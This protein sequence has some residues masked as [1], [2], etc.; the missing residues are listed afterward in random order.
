MK[1]ATTTAELNG[2]TSTPAEAVRAYEGTGFRYL[3]FSFYNAVSENGNYLMRDNWREYVLEALDVADKMGIKFVQAHAPSGAIRGEGSDTC[4]L[5]TERS[6]EACSMLGI[7]N[8]VIHSGFF[9]EIPYDGGAQQ[10]F[11]AN[12]PFFKALIPSME[13]FG[14][15]ILFENTTIKHCPNRCYFPITGK[16][17][18]AM[19]EYMEHP[20]FGAAWDVGHANLDKLS[21]DDE[22]RAMGNVLKAIHVHDNN[23]LTDLHLSPYL[24]TVNYDRLMR[25]LAD[26]GF[27]GYF[28]F[29][30]DAFFKYDRRWGREDRLAHPTPEIK[31]A[32]L[33]LLYKI[34]KTM[35]SEYGIYEE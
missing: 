33:C 27:D 8:M 14:V 30:A 16:D 19:V 34:G 32:A 4:L 26:I 2:F 12:A 5:A 31:K 28:T 23:G 9:P 29:E 21:Q 22:I 11:E 35:L 17:L 20:R 18:V 25:G 13:K 1:I 15:N 3:D 7:E 6:I 24:G 10:Y